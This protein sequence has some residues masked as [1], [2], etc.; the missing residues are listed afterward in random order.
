[1]RWNRENREKFQ[2]AMKLRHSLLAKYLV[3]IFMALLIWP[4][5]F[6]LSFLLYSIPQWFS[7]ESLAPANI[8]AGGTTI[9]KMWHREAEQLKDASPEMIDD[10]LQKLKQEY[11]LASMFWVDGQGDTRL[12]LLEEGALPDHWTAASSIQFM[13]ASYGGDPFTVVAFIGQDPNQGFMTIQIPR[14]LMRTEPIYTTNNSYFI[15]I[16]IS[17]LAFF[18]FVSWLFFYRIRKRLVH[19]QEAMTETN[20]TGIPEPVTVYQRDE[21]GQLERAF[22]HMIDEL[23]SGRQ[24]EKEEE[25]LRKQLIANLSHDIRTPLTAIRGHAYSLQKESLSEDGKKSVALIDSKVEDLSRLTENLMSYTLLSAGKYPLDIKETDVARLIRTSIA[26]WYPV[27]EKENFEVDVRLPE[28]AMYWKV[29]EQWFM[30][31]LDNLYQNI[32][33]H[34][35]SGHYIGI[36]SEQRAGTTAIAM[37]DKGPGMKAHSRD[38]GA[39]IGLSIVSMMVKEMRLDLE[40]SSSSE[41]T[42]IYLYPEILNK[43]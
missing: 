17:I 2:P 11:P 38:K 18:L 6:P 39:G 30:R 1:M 43:I 12:R 5:I 28:T 3:I 35:R 4:F 8:Y 41:G 14:S 25:Q 21:I 19:L 33:R 34:A 13:K 10:R 9:E 37:T 26:S 42:T 31:I 24:R 15:A 27:F 40:I 36:H 32:I 7:G 23:V 20:E 22:N 29:D 16:V